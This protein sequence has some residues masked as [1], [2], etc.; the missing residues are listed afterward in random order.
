ME[1]KL[2]NA[3]MLL[4]FAHKN[5]KCNCILASS[6]LSLFF[7]L[8]NSS[9][10]EPLHNLSMFKETLT[11]LS[12]RVHFILLKHR[13]KLR[14][15]TGLTNRE[16]LTVHDNNVYSSQCVCFNSL[17]WSFTLPLHTLPNNNTALTRLN[18]E[19]KW[20]TF[21]IHLNLTYNHFIIL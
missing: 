18:I 15:P 2:P 14:C 7:C 5:N 21:I 6:S 20:F 12:I 17:L 16:A 9:T 3:K 4:S 10:R 1:Y 19:M 13:E 11:K 8:A